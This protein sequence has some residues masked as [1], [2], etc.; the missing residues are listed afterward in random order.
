MYLDHIKS[1][2]GEEN[3]KKLSSIIQQLYEIN[4]FLREFSI[5]AFVDFRVI[6]H[7]MVEEAHSN[8]KY[9]KG[10]CI[11]SEMLRGSSLPSWYDNGRKDEPLKIEVLKVDRRNYELK[12][13]SL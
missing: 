11:K 10:L 3:D 1:V 7:V 4:A 13:V 6:R 12:T 2:L 5:P 9:I 8:E